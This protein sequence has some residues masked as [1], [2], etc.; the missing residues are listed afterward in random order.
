MPVTTRTTISPHSTQ[1]RVLSARVCTS[2]AFGP[3]NGLS[4]GMPQAPD[5]RHTSRFLG[6]RHPDQVRIAP[7]AIVYTS[8]AQTRSLACR[9]TASFTAQASGAGRPLCHEGSRERAEH[10]V[11][12]SA[13]EQSCASGHSSWSSLARESASPRIAQLRIVGVGLEL[14]WRWSSGSL[15]ARGRPGLTSARRRRGLGRSCW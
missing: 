9:L 5:Q 3:R 12:A 1:P 11:T 14:K 8:G 15:V 4:E 10:R 13:Q 7:A 2:L 6:R